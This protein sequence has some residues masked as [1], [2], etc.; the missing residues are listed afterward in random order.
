MHFCESISPVYGCLDLF[1][2]V[3]IIVS[4]DSFGLNHNCLL[5][6]IALRMDP[7]SI[8]VLIN[9]SLIPII[10]FSG[11][12]CLDSDSLAFWIELPESSFFR[13]VVH[14]AQIFILFSS[15]FLSLILFSCCLSLLAWIHSLLPGPFA[16]TPF[17][18]LSQSF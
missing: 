12:F 7:S 2:R 5:I 18:L 8:V 4:S 10:F 13:Y 17:L 11:F 9:W 6:R 14:F 3:P 15:C 16:G 1:S